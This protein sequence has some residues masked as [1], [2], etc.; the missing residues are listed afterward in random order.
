MCILL[1]CSCHKKVLQLNTHFIQIDACNRFYLVVGVDVS[2]KWV[3]EQI[4]TL[5]GLILEFMR[6]DSEGGIYTN[7]VQ[8]SW[9]LCK[10]SLTN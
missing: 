2:K 10:S 5:K 3:K 8:L 4:P 9:H 1:G 6:C 7:V